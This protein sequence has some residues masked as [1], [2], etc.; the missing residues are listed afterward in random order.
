M[1][2][3]YHLYG[4]AGKHSKFKMGAAIV[5]S[6]II[7]RGGTTTQVGVIAT[8]ATAF[9][10]SFGLA[11]DEGVFS[12]TQ[13]DAEGIVTVD[14]RPDL[15]I[16]ALICQGATENTALNILTNTAASAGGTVV[17]STNVSANDMDGG[18]VWSIR[19]NNAGL[20]RSVTADTASVSVT[21]TVPFPRAIAVDDQF[22]H[23]PYNTAGT[24][25]AD[26]RGVAWLTT[27]TL[28]TQANNDAAAGTG[29]EAYI[30]DLELN[31]ASDSYVLFMLRLH[32]YASTTLAS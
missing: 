32:A 21:V 28:F 2:A 23:T 26:A 5:D 24:G 14:V 27:T 20:S 7:V 31:G 17:T 18:T 4:G 15:A 13:G 19:G 1:Q 16:R 9:G 11:I 30:T 12:S 8:S 22:L 3:G 10:D 6:G 29:G 25:A